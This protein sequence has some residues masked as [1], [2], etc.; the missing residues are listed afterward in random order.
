MTTEN[1]PKPRP[2]GRRTIIENE[3]GLPPTEQS[4]IK[5]P[6]VKEP[7]KENK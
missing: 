1:N 7:K 2:E 6:D 3:K 5:K 4:Y